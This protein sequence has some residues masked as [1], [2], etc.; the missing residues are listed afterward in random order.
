MS[1]YQLGSIRY[2]LLTFTFA[3][4]SGCQTP[5]PTFEYRKP[6]YMEINGH[7]FVKTVATDTFGSQ[8][9]LIELKPRQLPY[10]GQFA[11]ISAQE[12]WRAILK[13]LNAAIIETCHGPALGNISFR[14]DRRNYLEE[15][16]N[17]DAPKFAQAKFQCKMQP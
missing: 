15:E 6:Q 16:A 13:E 14:A 17:L 12:R 5:Q 1:P 4:L 7:P 9:H 10:R 11:K 8:W 2:W 3:L